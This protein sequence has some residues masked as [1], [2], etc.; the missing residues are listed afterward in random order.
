MQLDHLH[1]PL[2][3]ALREGHLIPVV[4]TSARTG[5]GIGE[6]LEV[7]VKLLANP[8]EETPPVYLSLPVEGGDPVPLKAAPDPAAHALAHVFKIE[9]D[10]YI[11]RIAVC[12][13]HQG[14]LT[15][16]M[17]LYIGARRKKITP[18]QL[19]LLRA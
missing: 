10:P 17:Q 13:V 12:R 15:P 7:I 6:L 4:F 2:E 14:R 1:D 3:Q 11:G 16:N 5:A 9:S 8:L 19:F 18:A